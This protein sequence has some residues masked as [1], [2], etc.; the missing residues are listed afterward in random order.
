M[1]ARVITYDRTW[2]WNFGPGVRW[3][4][5]VYRDMARA[6]DHAETLT[7][8]RHQAFVMVA[9]A[10]MD[11][12]TADLPEGVHLEHHDNR[13]HWRCRRYLCT[14]RSRAGSVYPNGALL[15]VREHLV[16][17]HPYTHGLPPLRFTWPR[18]T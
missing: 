12:M 13:F 3:D 9:R 16:D 17:R 18:Y 10:Q 14:A 1:G 6:V 5:P 8:D 2:G 4:P 11:A 15:A 7:G